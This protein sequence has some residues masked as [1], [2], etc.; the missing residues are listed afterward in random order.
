MIVCHCNVIKRA[1]IVQATRDM[2]A[3][4]PAASLEPQS[5]YK[6]LKRRGRCCG[7]FPTV[8]AIVLEV[9]E[10]A[11]QEVDGVSL[12]TVSHG[13]RLVPKEIP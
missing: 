2:L 9:L 11:M 12:L 5:V 13:K 4:D 1:E 10:S 6:E 7:C 3:A 8:R